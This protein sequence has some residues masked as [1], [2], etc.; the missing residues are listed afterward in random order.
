[1]IVELINR[2]NSDTKPKQENPSQQNHFNH[3]LLERGNNQ[4]QKT[5]NE[6]SNGRIIVIPCGNCTISK[7][8]LSSLIISKF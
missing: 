7:T 5:S 2:G 3:K 8:L 1:M 4:F 6:I